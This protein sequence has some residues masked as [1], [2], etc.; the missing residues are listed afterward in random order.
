MVRIGILLTYPKLEQNKDELVS[1]FLEKDASGLPWQNV[2]DVDSRHL[3]FKRRDSRYQANDKLGVPTD[4]AVGYYIRHSCLKQGVEVD[5]ILPHEISMERLRSND[6]NF[7]LIYDVLEAFH[8]DK[9]DGKKI[10]N[11]LLRCLKKADNIY[12]PLEYQELIYSKIKYYNY[13]KEHKVDILPTVTMT[14]EE[15][16]ELGEEKA[17]KK[18]LEHAQGEQWGRFIAKP[19]Y[20]Q[21]SKDLKFFEPMEM[22]SFKRYL[23]KCMNKYPGIVAQKAVKFFGKSPKSPEL[24]M[25]HIGDEYKYSV[26]FCDKQIMRPDTEGGTLP[27]PME[28]LKATTR[29]IIRK[30]PA[31]V[32]PNGCRLPRLL[33]RLDMGYMVDGEFQPFVNEVEFVPSLYSEDTP[34]PVINNFIKGLGQQIVKITQQYVKNRASSQTQDLVSRSP[35]KTQTG[36]QKRSAADAGLDQTPKKQHAVRNEPTPSKV[37]AGTPSKVKAGKRSCRSPGKQ[38]VSQPS[39][40]P[41]KARR[42]S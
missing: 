6:L 7:L 19:V 21:E 14:K 25:Y 10:Y 5:F 9:T 38:A 13:L 42:S 17:A 41:L 29:K 3:L 26:C 28:K 36:A 27:A 40:R 34:K 11:T 1:Q 15:Y 22:G 33:T 35:K 20:G 8:T 24:R 18:V 4:A 16:K 39:A 2:V 32:M 30:L 12:P 37:K 23:S 31:I